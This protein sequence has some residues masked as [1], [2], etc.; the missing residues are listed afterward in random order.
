MDSLEELQAIEAIREK[1]R[2]GEKLTGKEEAIL[3]Y[4][5]YGSAG[6]C[7]CDARGPYGHQDHK[8]GSGY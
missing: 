4:S 7:K 2:R 1:Q 8:I 6:A 3:A 5:P